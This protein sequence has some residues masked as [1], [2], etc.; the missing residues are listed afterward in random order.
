[1]TV[2]ELS[3]ASNM[4][5]ATIKRLEAVRGLPPAHARTIAALKKALE[6]SGVEFIGSLDDR[7][8]VRLNLHKVSK[9]PGAD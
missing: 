6:D 4:G 3:L 7:P 5:V 1:M 8:G 9:L 2:A